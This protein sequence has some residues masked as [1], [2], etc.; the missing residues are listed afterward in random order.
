MS[1][2]EIL[3]RHTSYNVQKVLWLAE[4]L[5]L[6][7]AHTEV[8]GRFGGADT[9]Q[10]LALNPLGKVP[11][12]RH[13]DKV[14]RESNTIVRYLADIFSD[15][16]WISP[17]AYQRSLAEQWMDWSIEKLEPAFVGVF[18][19][20]YRTPEERRDEAAIRASVAQYESCIDV[21][22]AVLA[23]HDF[24]LG[25]RPS[26][27]DIATGVFLYRMIDIDLPIAI[28]QS[29]HDWYG[30]LSAMDGYQ[31]WVM[32]DYSELRGRVAY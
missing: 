6:D 31:R 27:A 21:L 18:W 10:F 4:E 19:G 22:A 9:S 28:P 13:G 16:L 23:E 30:R 20:Y 14:L 25:A 2:I 24:L 15:G 3:G 1:K 8:G 12:M 7:Y 11:V 32:S 29:V 17:R 26:V 5:K